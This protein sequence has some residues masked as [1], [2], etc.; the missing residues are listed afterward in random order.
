[1]AKPIGRPTFF[2]ALLL[3][4]IAGVVLTLG[5]MSLQ[6]PSQS[7]H[8]QKAQAPQAVQ[9]PQGPQPKPEALPCPVKKPAAIPGELVN[10]L[11]APKASSPAA[12][13]NELMALASKPKDAAMVDPLRWLIYQSEQGE[14]IRNQ[15]LVVLG[16]WDVEWLESD[17]ERMMFDLGQTAV[18][19]AYCVQ[20]LKHHFAKHQDKASYDALVKAASASGEGLATVHETAIYSLACLAKEQDWKTTQPERHAEVLRHIGAAMANPAKGSVVAG[21]R[22]SAVLELR[23]RAAALE[24]LA[25]DKARPLEIRVA[26]VQALGAIGREES[27]KVLEA[28]AKADEKILAQAAATA[29]SARSRQP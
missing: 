16:A 18:W 10:T 8:S 1:M 20:H 9:K 4:L 27:R 14:V 12:A 5:W 26:A 2:V 15:A 24:G 13:M 28:C 19:R 17:L 6:P 7:D 29:L 25:G 3:L 22:S 23:E 21:I 11:S